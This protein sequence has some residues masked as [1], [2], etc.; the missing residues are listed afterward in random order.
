MGIWKN[1]VE[2]E[3]QQNNI[4]DFTGKVVEV[5]S[6][7]C[8]T[9]EK[10]GDFK[11]VKIYLASIKAPKLTNDTSEAYGWESKESLRKL[12]IGKKVKV[13]VEYSKVVPIKSGEIQM[14]FGSVFLTS[15]N[16]KNVAAAQLERGLAKSNLHKDQ[17]SRYL[18]DL[19]TAEK[20][21]IDAKLCLHSKREP[22]K[23]IFNDLISNTK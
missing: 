12:A 17:M 9:I 20:K 15:K 21:A 5:H 11:L 19:L 8:L 10:D 22:P 14:N 16:D 13:V 7:D 3:K 2:E 18:E 4:E 23:I 1:H 6:G